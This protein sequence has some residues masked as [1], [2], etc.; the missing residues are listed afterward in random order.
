M[1]L[2]KVLEENR[3]VIELKGLYT[4]ISLACCVGL[5]CLKLPF[6]NGFER[7]IVLHISILSVLL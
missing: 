7:T 2:I 4:H 1:C 3:I 6:E 5:S